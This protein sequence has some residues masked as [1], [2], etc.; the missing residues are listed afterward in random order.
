LAS[1]GLKIYPKPFSLIISSLAIS[2]QSFLFSIPASHPQGR[3]SVLA[4]PG[5]DDVPLSESQKGK[6][7]PS[8]ICN[9]Y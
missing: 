3:G 9:P 2:L 6:E 7:G 5:K 8:L 1:S 4:H